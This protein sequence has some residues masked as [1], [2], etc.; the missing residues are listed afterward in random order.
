MLRLN[1]QIVAPPAN[2]D[3]ANATLI[4]ALPFS[5]SSL[6][7]SG[8]TTE[9]G[10]Q[11]LCTPP[12]SEKT[13]WYAYMADRNGTVSARITNTPVPVAVAAYTGGSLTSLMRLACQYGSF[14][15]SGQGEIMLVGRPHSA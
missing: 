5:D 7:L 13:A 8:A 9:V 3:F 4:S 1:E 14:D 6:D 12:A 11:A 2:D 10:E 15:L